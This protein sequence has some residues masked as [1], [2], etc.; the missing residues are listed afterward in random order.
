MDHKN[1]TRNWMKFCY[2]VMKEFKGYNKKVRVCMTNILVNI[3][4]R[5]KMTYNKIRM[6]IGEYR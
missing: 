5:K 6:L 1:V 2:M 3:L 4:I